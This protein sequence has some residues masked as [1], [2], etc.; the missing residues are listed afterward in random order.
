MS[1]PGSHRASRVGWIIGIVLVAWFSIVWYLGATDRFARPAGTPPLPIL[2]GAVVPIVLFL[3]A[4]RLSPSFHEFTRTADPRFLTAL[5]SWRFAGIGFLALYTSGVLPGSFA[6]PAGLGD[7][8]IGITAPFVMLALFRRPEFVSSRLFVTW[9]VLGIL[10]LVVAVSTG[11]SASALAT[12]APGEITTA[13]MAL[14]PLV[15]I[16]TFFVPIFVM[17][18]LAVLFQAAQATVPHRA[19]AAPRRVEM[20]SPAIG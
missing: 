11:A 17:A 16:P 2:F 20:A 3:A 4:Y 19:D 7:I 5:Q 13:P 1:S 10:D 14:L 12:G 15:L 18:H 6:W 9:N 8:A